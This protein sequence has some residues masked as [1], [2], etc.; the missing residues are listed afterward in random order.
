M[1]SS[2]ANLLMKYYRELTD[3]KKAIPSFHITVST[4]QEA[5]K[6]VS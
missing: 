1:S 4:Q 2:S 5:A 3:P 6:V